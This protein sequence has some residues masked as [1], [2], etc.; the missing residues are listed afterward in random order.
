L[1]ELFGSKTFETPKPL[2]LI[3]WIIGLHADENG[4]VL[5]SFAGSGTTGHAVMQLNKEDGGNRHFIR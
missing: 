4:T 1:K 3:K 5:D 2:L